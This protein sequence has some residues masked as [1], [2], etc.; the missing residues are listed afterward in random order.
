ML[1]SPSLETGMR[2]LL[3]QLTET[4]D[5]KVDKQDCKLMIATRFDEVKCVFKIFSFLYKSLYFLQVSNTIEKLS[6]N[7]EIELG[8]KAT[9]DE[10]NAQSIR[11]SETQKVCVICFIQ[12]QR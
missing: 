6:L 3:A 4:L 7:T 10:V 12:S 2:E 8:L 5:E 11:I 9:K 1:P